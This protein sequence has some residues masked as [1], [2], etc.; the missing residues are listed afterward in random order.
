MSQP[1]ADP[2]NA[3]GQAL[4]QA[5][6]QLSGASP[7][8]PRPSPHQYDR[9]DE[10][11]GSVIVSG[12]GLGLPGAN[13]PVMD[14]DNALRILRGEQFVDLIPER[15][16][17]EMAGK[18]I[19]R[20]VKGE[21][22]SGSFEV[23]E[24]TDDAAKAPAVMM[25]HIDVTAIAPGLP[26]SVAPDM[27]GFLRDDL[28]FEGVALT[29]DLADPAITTLSSVP[30]AAVRAVRAGADMLLVSGP[31]GDQQAAYVAV[32]RAVRAGR[33]PRERV[34][35]AVGRILVAKENYGLIR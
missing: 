17:K 11:T 35:Q 24:S 33:I 25:A 31:A 9:N 23:I 27:Y 10:P 6:Q 14:P 8:A 13:K 20:V 19:T 28:G 4:L 22:G 7:L 34:D 2:T 18:R 12:T 26:G 21:D 15:F 5:L 16:R 32:L 3:L 30:G 1:A 29:D